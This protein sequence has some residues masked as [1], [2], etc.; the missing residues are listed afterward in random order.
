[1]GRARGENA[2]FFPRMRSL[3]SHAITERS[4]YSPR[5]TADCILASADFTKLY[6][7]LS[8]SCLTYHTQREFGAGT[9][10]AHSAITWP[11]AIFKRSN[12]S[13]IP[14]ILVSNV[15]SCIH[16]RFLYFKIVL[17]NVLRQYGS[18]SLRHFKVTVLRSIL[19]NKNQ[20]WI[21]HRAH[22]RWFIIHIRF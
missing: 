11:G 13:S 15:N 9:H 12:A 5:A 22:F 4:H 18:I 1:M 19:N 8:S 2:R 10:S 6:I 7:A 16:S 3:Q 20:Q 14:V 17:N 21:N